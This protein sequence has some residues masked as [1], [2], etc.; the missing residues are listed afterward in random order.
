MRMGAL[1]RIDLESRDKSL[2]VAKM[3]D[4]S[5]WVLMN[6]RWID[7][8]RV[9]SQD[10]SRDGKMNLYKSGVELAWV[11]HHVWMPERDRGEMST[12]RSVRSCGD[13]EVCMR[14]ECIHEAM[15]G[16]C[17]RSGTW[18]ISMHEH[19]GSVCMSYNMESKSCNIYCP[20]D[21]M[22]G[23][24]LTKALPSAKVKYFATE[25][26]LSLPWGGVLD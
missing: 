7:M 18:R 14:D 10:E 21:N 5:E 24:T 25:L 2:W 4:E 8:T 20:T 3:K 1:L 16:W 23:D 26:R 19:G 15:Q 22:V 6:R 12:C 11:V 9:M 13:A 17:V